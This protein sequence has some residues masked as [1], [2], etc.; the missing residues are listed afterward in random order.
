MGHICLV[1]ADAVRF[2]LTLLCG[3][4]LFFIAGQV[5]VGKSYS[6]IFPV[7]SDTSC[8]PD[9]MGWFLDT[10]RLLPSMNSVLGFGLFVISYPGTERSRG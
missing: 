4:R 6:S 1:T 3:A 10:A 7:N 8:V 9:G 2:Y 5:V